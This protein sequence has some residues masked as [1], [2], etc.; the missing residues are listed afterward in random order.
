M[1]AINIAEIAVL[2]EGSAGA[3]GRG[4]GDAAI[5]NKPRPFPNGATTT[6]LF[7]VRYWL[8]LLFFVD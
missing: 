6:E 2:P 5:G 4:G 1:K 7:F 3:D 8:L